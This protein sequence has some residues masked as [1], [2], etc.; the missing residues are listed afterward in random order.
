[1]LLII[2]RDGSCFKCPDDQYYDFYNNLCVQCVNGT[3]YD[4]HTGTCVVKENC[5]VEGAVFN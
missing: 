2:S 1:M 5:L 3:V 4:H